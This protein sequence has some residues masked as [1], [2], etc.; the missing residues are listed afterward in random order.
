L[1]RGLLVAFAALAVSASAAG[2]IAPP[3]FEPLNIMGP[4]ASQRFKDIRIEQHLDAQVPIELMFTNSDGQP[5]SIAEALDGKP[6][7]LALVYYECPMLCN[8]MLDGVEG[9]VDAVKYE[10]G[11]DYNV[12][13]VS[14]DPGETPELAAK[15]KAAHLER[16]HRDGAEPGWYFLTGDE[17]GI[18]RLA[19]TV[20]FRYA[21]D[22]ATGQY[23][24]AAG[25]MVLTPGGRVA[26]YYFGTE[27]LAR[28]VE[29]GLQE[30]SAGKI[31][32]L[33]DQLLLLCFHYDPATGT[34]GF[35]VMRA[36]QVSGGLMVLGFATMYALL[37]VRW[38]RAN[39]GRAAD[40]TAHAGRAAASQPPGIH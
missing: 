33:V 30:A 16:L 23:A 27:Y 39:R 17:D 4:D 35:Y 40:G 11:S 19:G 26:R 14:I 1:V 3:P 15:K 29:F 8:V 25:I 6:A 9:V 32:S 13:T 28:D 7:I 31:G 12:I 24:H 10:V 18:E 34:Y 5:I 2:Q 20:G 22:P 36:L 37:F 38:R 21:Y